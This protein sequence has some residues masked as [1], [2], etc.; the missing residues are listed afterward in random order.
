MA[1]VHSFVDYFKRA[2]SPLAVLSLLRRKPM[3]G[4]EISQE[5]NERGRG[6]LTVAVL[7][8]VLYRLEQQG[9]VYISNTT[10]ENGRARSY[11]ALTSEGEIYLDQTVAE[12]KEL[13]EIFLSM[14]EEEE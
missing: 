10:V 8:S 9:Y 3:Y 4:Y 11:Y 13:S 7:Y 6:K 2:V 5:M 14:F 12:Y 1:E